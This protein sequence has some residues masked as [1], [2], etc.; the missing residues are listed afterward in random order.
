MIINDTNGNQWCYVKIPRTGTK[1]Y[2]SLFDES[3]ANEL[4]N[5]KFYPQGHAPY[6]ALSTVNDSSVKYFT[7][8]R[9]PVDRFI[10]SLRYMFERKATDSRISFDIP[11]D[12]IHNMVSF[13]YENFDRNCQPKGKTLAD[14]FTANNEWFI[15]AFF[16]TQTFWASD[17]SITVF[18]Y[19][20]ITE[21]NDWLTNNFTYDISKLQTLDLI[22][23]DMLTHLDF[24]D[25]E[26][27]QLVEHLFY[28][29]FTTFNYPLSN[30]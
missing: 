10:S 11:N 26:F 1:E 8:V 2:T 16:K 12:T 4:K 17:A 5:N 24:S 28:E 15:G 13:F 22:E 20:N 18:K 6:S 7:V 9:N 21:F 14:I 23:T 30:S 27:V 25:P 19:E 29:D 3:F